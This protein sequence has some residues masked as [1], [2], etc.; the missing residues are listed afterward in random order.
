[1]HKGFCSLFPPDEFLRSPSS[2]RGH[3]PS[4]GRLCNGVDNRGFVWHPRKN[5]KSTDFKQILNKKHLYNICLTSADR[6]IIH[7]CQTDLKQNIRITSV[8]KQK[9][10]STPCAWCKCLLRSIERWTGDWL[11][12]ATALARERSLSPVHSIPWA[13]MDV[14][15]LSC[16]SVGI[17][18]W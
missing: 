7:R 13:K 2:P 14:L 10:K 3:H 5:N 18:C 1:M 8:E 12:F 16:I 15:Y 6:N 17:Y 9:P 11:P 4:P